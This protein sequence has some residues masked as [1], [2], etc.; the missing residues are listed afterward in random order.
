VKCNHGSTI[1]QLNDEAFFYL[2]SRGIGEDEARSLLVFAFASEIVD[3]MKVEAVREQVR[4]A[5]FRQMP[6]RMPERR[7]G[8]R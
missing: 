7:G 1:G 4:R 8:P 6:D 5:L 3:R 2:R